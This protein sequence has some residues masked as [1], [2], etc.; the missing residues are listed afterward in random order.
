MKTPLRIVVCGAAFPFGLLIG[1]GLTELVFDGQL[2]IS[3]DLSFLE[4]LG[5]V[6]GAIALLWGLGCVLAA[7]VVT[8]VV[9]LH[10]FKRPRTMA[11]VVGTL[12]PAIPSLFDMIR[13]RSIFV[14]Q[15]NLAL[16]FAGLCVG[17]AVACSG[18]KSVN[19]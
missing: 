5:M 12:I 19:G 10:K 17:I 11:L 3:K 14:S 16:A 6:V 7:I 1:L 15:D 13:G 9:A 18:K 2:H 4:L 8:A